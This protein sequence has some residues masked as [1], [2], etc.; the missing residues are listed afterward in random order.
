ME[1]LFNHLVNNDSS[2]SRETRPEDRETLLPNSNAFSRYEKHSRTTPSW[3]KA[4]IITISLLAATAF[5]AWF[6]RQW[7]INLDSTCT[8]HVSRYCKH[9]WDMYPA[10]V[11]Q[12][13]RKQQ[14]LLSRT[15]IFRTT[16][17]DSTAHF[18]R[19]MCFG[20]MLD[21]WWMRHGNH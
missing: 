21:Q 2:Q 11:Q 5:G 3:I 6:G 9:P 12:L 13:I 19:K 20:K 10:L 16:R 17:S 1:K 4:L 7:P 18:S 14:P 15:L 8:R